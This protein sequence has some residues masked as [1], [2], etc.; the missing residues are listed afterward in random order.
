[1]PK[2]PLI[3]NISLENTST[4]L[5]H[6][7]RPT[8]FETPSKNIIQK[9]KTKSKLKIFGAAGEVNSDQ[10]DI[11]V[12]T[13]PYSAT[14]RKD[15]ADIVFEDPVV[16]PAMERRHGAL[17]ENGYK[18]VLEL[19]SIY[20]DLGDEMTP[21]EIKQ[22]LTI[23]GKEYLAYLQAI[24]S[25]DSKMNNLEL[26]RRVNTSSLT[27]GRAAV[28]ITPP[29]AE[30][31]END[32]DVD[33]GYDVQKKELPIALELINYEDLGD[34]LVDIKYSHSLVAV[35]LNYP[36]Q[37]VATVDQLLYVTRKDWGLR[38]ES[39]F[40]GSSIFEAIPKISKALKRIYNRDFP[41]AVIAA[42]ITKLIFRLDTDGDPDEQR[43]KFTEFLNKFFTA[44]NYAVAVNQDILEVTPVPI[45]VDTEMLDTVE[46]KLADLELGTT[47]VPNSMLNRGHDLNRDLATIEAIQFI[48]YVQRPDEQLI[49]KVFEEQLYNRLLAYLSG[50]QYDD[51]PVCI[52]VVANQPKKEGVS[53]LQDQTN[54]TEQKTNEI[55]QGNI[56]QDDAQ[57]K[58][59]GASGYKVKENQDGTYDVTS[60][61][62]DGIP[63]FVSKQKWQYDSKT[64]NIRFI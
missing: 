33:L 26:M 9:L 8:S 59:F 41:D 20:N 1:M 5:K 56:S 53:E 40:F 38:K 2:N 17:F 25:W 49:A 21:D 47:G 55:D 3:A 24:R 64:N 18:L 57:N 12:M 43:T 42:Y 54:L 63:R 48:K 45:S 15:F 50:K 36:D 14:T 44:G 34:P 30:P 60:L 35:Q 52:R 10:T 6:P 23:T 11:R 22:K 19:K 27:Q 58:I 32:S 28:L 46:K 61:Q 29:I 31:T 13:D 7:R 51:L 4:I 62:T 16:A 39:E 37:N